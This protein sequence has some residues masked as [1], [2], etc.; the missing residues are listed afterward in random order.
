MIEL[1]SLVRSQIDR[2]HE[3]Y[4]LKYSGIQLTLEYCHETMG[5]EIKLD[6]GIG[7]VPSYYEKAK[8]FYIQ[9]KAVE[10]SA[11]D[12]KPDQIKRV[13]NVNVKTQPKNR[14]IDMEDLK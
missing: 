11:K 2:Y 6:Y 8:S 3:R 1:P 5:I 9:R 7:I 14:M 10:K 13:I 4:G 12:F